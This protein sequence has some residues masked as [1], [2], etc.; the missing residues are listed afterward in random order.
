MMIFCSRCQREIGNGWEE[1]WP[2]FGRIEIGFAA[3]IGYALGLGSPFPD[4][5]NGFRAGDAQNLVVEWGQGY[6][7][8][9]RDSFILCAGCQKVLLGLI[10]AFF[11]GKPIPPKDKEGEER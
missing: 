5:L 9:T 4:R 8:D 6:R 1:Q 10:G 2:N 7:F 11:G 3:Q